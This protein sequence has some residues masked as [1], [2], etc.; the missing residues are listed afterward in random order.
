MT[1][2][3]QHLGQGELSSQGSGHFCLVTTQLLCCCLEVTDSSHF[4]VAGQLE[5]L[6]A[7]KIVR[8]LKGI[9]LISIFEVESLSMFFI[10]HSKCTEPKSIEVQLHFDL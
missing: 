10:L 8:N 7:F 9:P 1:K 3:E 6:V 5:C 2:Q 4:S